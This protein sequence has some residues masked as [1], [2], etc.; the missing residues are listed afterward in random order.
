MA[1]CR[2]KDRKTCTGFIEYRSRS[3]K[4]TFKFQ[5][6]LQTQTTNSQAKLQTQTTNSQ[7]KL[8]T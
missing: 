4:Q 3:Q 1:Q 6:G 8:Q 2:N 7:A 5:L